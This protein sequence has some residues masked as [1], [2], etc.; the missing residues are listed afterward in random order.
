MYGSDPLENMTRTWDRYS[1]HSVTV[2]GNLLKKYTMRKS[3]PSARMKLTWDY[4]KSIRLP[5][6]YDDQ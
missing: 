1:T 5:T 6:Y 4:G 2:M 3:L